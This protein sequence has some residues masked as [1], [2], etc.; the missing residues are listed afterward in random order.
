MLG[1]CFTDNV[2]T[3]LAV[4]GF[5]VTHNP[6]GTLYNPMS[7]LQAMRR[8]LG[9]LPPYAEPDLTPGPDGNLHC[10]D[11]STKYT[12]PDASRLLQALND[13]LRKL[14]DRLTRSKTVIITFGTSYRAGASL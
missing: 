6:M 3:L 1:S 14:G 9:D 12:S 7:I 8:A 4:D 13:D 11:F 5:D 10:L 2:G